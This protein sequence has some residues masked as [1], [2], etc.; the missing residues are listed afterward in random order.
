MMIW[1][2]LVLEL[3]ADDELSHTEHGSKAGVGALDGITSGSG[4]AV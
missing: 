3:C 2:Q 1:A 4:S